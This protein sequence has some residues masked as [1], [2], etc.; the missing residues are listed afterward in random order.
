MIKEAGLPADTEETIVLT[1]AEYEVLAGFRY[2]LRQFLQFSERAAEVFGLT[3]QKY[4]AMLAIKGFPGRERI[5]IGELA[6]QLGIRHHSAVGLVDR[7]EE[8]DMVVREPD[9]IDRRQVY[10]RLTEK[11][12]DRLTQLAATHKEECRRIGPQLN[13]FLTRLTEHSSNGNGT[14]PPV[15]SPEASNGS[16]P[17]RNG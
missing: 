7:L 1:K 9:R 5:T 17:G 14:E 16:A 3:P 8:Q 2:G 15:E 12:A 13:D 11:G 10:I 6:N 4:Q